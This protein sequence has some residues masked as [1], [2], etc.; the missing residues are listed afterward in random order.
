MNFK[1]KNRQH[2]M[3]KR[4]IIIAIS[5]CFSIVSCNKENI[6]S[7]YCIKNI[8]NSPTITILSESEMDIVKHL[9]NH[10]QL[11]YTKYLFT[12]FQEDKLGHRHIRC[13]QFANNLIVFTSDAIFHFDENDN[14]YYPLS[15]NLINE[16][17]LDTKS[18]TTRDNIV[19]KYIDIV[20]HDEDFLAQ[21]RFEDIHLEDVIEGCF[22]IEFG[23]YNLNIGISSAE[24]N[25]TKAWKIKFTDRDYPY[26]Y[27]N[28][29]DIVIISYDNGILY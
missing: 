17:N 15:G 16:I 22:D 10:N 20:A 4:T 21:L 9:F 29:E 12:K 26:A 7:L 24:E 19:E 1:H 5:L 3:K 13:Y 25:Y 6:E 18:L 28:D 23:Y 8:Q 2:I 11:D 27:I 14:Y